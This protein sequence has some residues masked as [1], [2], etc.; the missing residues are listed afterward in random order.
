LSEQFKTSEHPDA[1]QLSAFADRALPPDEERQTFAHLAQCSECRSIVYLAQ[2]TEF[3]IQLQTK[4]AGIH[5]RVRKP[6]FQGWAL[7]WPT[8]AALACIVFAVVYAHHINLLKTD[9]TTAPVAS[10]KSAS[11]DIRAMPEPQPSPQPARTRA[12]QPGEGS[13]PRLAARG[14][15]TGSQTILGKKLEG[16]QVS[17]RDTSSLMPGQ[18]ES[19]AQSSGIRAM[20]IAKAAPADHLTVGTGTGA[21]SGSATAVGGVAGLS[22]GSARSNIPSPRQDAKASAPA[23]TSSS[24]AQDTAVQGQQYPAATPALQAGLPTVTIQT[25]SEAERPATTNAAMVG[26]AVPVDDTAEL[27][28]AVNL[29]SHLAAISTI[30]NARMM[31]AIDSGGSLFFSKDAGQHW[32]SIAPRWKGR[33]VRVDSANPVTQTKQIASTTAEETA[34]KVPS[35]PLGSMQS[36]VPHAVPLRNGALTGIVTDR[37][38]AVVP[39]ANVAMTNASTSETHA[40]KTDGTGRYIVDTLEPG[41]YRLEAYSPGFET[42]EINGIMVANSRPAV[43]NVVLEVGAASQAVTVT[44]GAPTIQTESA[45]ISETIDNGT[46]ST[47]P[48]VSFELTTNTGAVYTSTD[49]RH[50]KPK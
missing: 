25:A 28:K 50:W 10:N 40:V 8:A 20:A 32:K 49:G 17:G 23:P 3:E 42:A 33:A 48:P 12:A 21:G 18:P 4:P 36:P 6:W 45:Q 35:A 44:E 38:G 2:G 16:F 1:D 19:A 5:V 26:A 43:L 34:L 37:T 14:P 29:P 22:Y 7:S 15:A 11:A 41:V 31:L 27:R 30:S 24:I 13:A 47:V 9:E 46:R 39:N